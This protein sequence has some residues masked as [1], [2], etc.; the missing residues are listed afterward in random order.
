MTLRP[1]DDLVEHGSRGYG[2]WVVP[3]RLLG[4]GSRCYLVGVGE[5]IS[6]D[7]ALIAR[8]GCSV[9]AF[10]PVPAAATHAAVAA[11]HERRFHF[12][13]V[14]LWSGDTTLPLHAPMEE[15]YV[16]HSA[17]NLHGTRKAFDAPVRSV[18]SVMRELGDDAIDLLKI[19]AEGSEYE[20]LDSLAKDAVNVGVICIEFAQP[21]PTGASE[22]AVD[23]LIGR[24]YD[25]VHA[26]VTPWTWKLT[27]V[28]RSLS[29]EV[30]NDGVATTTDEQP[31]I[32]RLLEDGAPA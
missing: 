23:Q 19:S 2:F 26:R 7:L 11:A 3:S 21:A 31:A 13:A 28:H 17:T 18:A 30:V 8:Y 4:Q 5:D 20:I 16:S 29:M 14:G 22:R 12:H 6:F 27:F 1:R 25:L 32:H 9:H 10:D 15:G 24:G